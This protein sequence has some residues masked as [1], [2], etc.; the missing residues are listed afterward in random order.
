M[1]TI[2]FESGVLDLAIMDAVYDRNALKLIDGNLPVA[3]L[4]AEEIERSPVKTD[5][6]ALINSMSS[7]VRMT[8]DGELGFS[9]SKKR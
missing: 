5:V 3:T 1:G 9:R 6:K 8:N 4:T 2:L 7:D